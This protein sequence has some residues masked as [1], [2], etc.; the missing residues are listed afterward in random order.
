[1]TAQ[2]ENASAQRDTHR[3]AAHSAILRSAAV[4]GPRSCRAGSTLYPFRSPGTGVI[5]IIVLL[6]DG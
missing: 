5:D 6:T 2:R 4:L 3:A 1:M